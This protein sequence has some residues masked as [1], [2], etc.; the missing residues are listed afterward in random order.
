MALD[1]QDCSLAELGPLGYAFA[2]GTLPDTRQALLSIRL[3]G[4]FA[5]EHEGVFDYAAAVVM[6]GLEAW[7]PWAVIL[8]LRAVT[9]SWGDRMENVLMASQ[10]WFLPLRPALNV[11]AG[12]ML[13]VVMP[14]TIVVSDSC[15]D[16]MASL[17][18][19]MDR[20]P[21]EMLFESMADAARALDRMLEG[22][23]LV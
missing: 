16:G 7:Q 18:R 14:Q 10:R 12:G 9:Y 8:D 11:F 23:P 1:L 2:R 19:Y 20:E 5:N 13:P 3:E 22:V 17:L 21:A 15:R 6:A 4:E